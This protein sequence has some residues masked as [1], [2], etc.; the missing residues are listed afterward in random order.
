MIAPEVKVAGPNER[1][2]V[3][4]TLTLA[5]TVDP[6]IRWFF[7]SADEYLQYFTRFVLGMGGRAFEHGTAFYLSDFSAAALWLPPNVTSDQAALT[8]MFGALAWPEEKAMDLGGVAAQVDAHH[9]H[10]PHWYLAFLGADAAYQGKGLGS[11]LMKHALARCDREH[12]PA[13]LESSSPKN[14]PFYE[15]HGFEAIGRVQ[16]GSSPVITPMLR[17]PR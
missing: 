7:P 5:F 8:E 1:E 4:N 3:L 17:Q 12:L 13:Y 11:M 16:A 14:V 15:R 6:P 2:S 10:E 9:P